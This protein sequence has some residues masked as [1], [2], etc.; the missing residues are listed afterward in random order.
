MIKKFF[1]KL[2]FKIGLCPRSMYEI[3]NLRYIAM[4]KYMKLNC[5]E[6]SICITGLSKEELK[7]LI[8]GISKEIVRKASQEAI[9]ILNK[10]KKGKK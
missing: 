5:P 7:E 9:E 1:T 6:H 2:L 8:D 10:Y 4:Q 3:A